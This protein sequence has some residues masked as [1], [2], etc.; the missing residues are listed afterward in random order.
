MTLQ[1]LE[2][3]NNNTTYATSGPEWLVYYLCM[4]NDKCMLH[5]FNYKIVKQPC[6][7]WNKTYWARSG[8]IIIYIAQIEYDIVIDGWGQWET[9]L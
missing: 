3:H 1:L 2:M 7:M 8:D 9:W 4:L 6:T 5:V